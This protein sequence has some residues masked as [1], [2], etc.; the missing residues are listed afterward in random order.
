ML[1]SKKHKRLMKQERF[2]LQFITLRWERSERA[3]YAAVRNQMEKALSLPE[4]LFS[5]D[6]DYGQPYHK[7]VMLHNKKGL[8]TVQDQVVRLNPGADK[9]KLGCIEIDK[10]AVNP[11]MM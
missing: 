1:D 7:V 10:R 9:W 3:P 11:N 8:E 4:N 2:L 6:T 5:Y